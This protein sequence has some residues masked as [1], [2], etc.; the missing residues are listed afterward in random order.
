MG[1][2]DGTELVESAWRSEG[3]RAFQELAEVTCSWHEG[4]WQGRHGQD[5]I[6]QGLVGMLGFRS[7]PW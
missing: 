2:A 4:R 7:G 6:A 5:R 3:Y 1:R